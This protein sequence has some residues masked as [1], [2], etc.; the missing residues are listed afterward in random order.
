MIKAGRYELDEESMGRIYQHVVSNPKTKSWAVITASRGENT[1][2]ENARKN[3]DLENDLRKMGLGFVHADGMWRECKNRSIEYKDCPEELRVPSPEKVLFIPNIPKDKAVALG[4]KYEQDS[5]L[6]ADEETKAKGEA[7]FIDSKS[8]E[9]FNIGKFT[10]G[11]IA[12][13]YTKMKG[14]KVFTFLQ[15]GEK[16]ITPK[17][18][19]KKSDMKLKSLLPKDVLDKMV[20]NPETGN[21]IKLKTALRH[22]KNSP[23]Y[24]SAVTMVKQTK[25]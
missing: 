16:G 20:K 15:P 12:Q 11:K 3:K 24:K 7:T 13:G 18:E 5:V 21:M 4:K 10:P 17:E 6:F 2:A 23:V 19:P 25:K 8:G 1:P 22:D 9:S 14:G